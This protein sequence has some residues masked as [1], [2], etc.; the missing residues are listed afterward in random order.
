MRFE[1][2]NKALMTDAASLIAPMVPSPRQQSSA[3]SDQLSDADG[4]SAFSM[5]LHDNTNA[6][7]KARP[8]SGAPKH[9]SESKHAKPSGDSAKSKD[10][11]TASVDNSKPA[12]KDS[13]AKSHKSGKPDKKADAKA[14]NKDKSE[15]AAQQ[16]LVAASAT[17]A[18]PA[19]ATID[20]ATKKAADAAGVAEASDSA[21]AKGAPGAALPQADKNAKPGAQGN[22]LA[23]LAAVKP[24]VDGVPTTQ[25][26][27]KS[28][29]KDGGKESTAGNEA[30]AAL[31]V[32]TEGKTAD[33]KGATPK[34]AAASASQSALA[35]AKKDDAPKNGS[36]E[37]AA[38][39]NTNA[40]IGVSGTLAGAAQSKPAGQS[41][42]AGDGKTPPTP[43]AIVTTASSST[44]APVGDKLAA[45]PTDAASPKSD[46][47]AQQTLAATQDKPAPHQ[48]ANNIPP[49]QAHAADASAALKAAAQ[50]VQQNVPTQGAA[51]G[52]PQTQNSA[53]I[54]A[55]IIHAGDA[56]NQGAPTVQAQMDGPRL[57]LPMEQVAL[58]I[59]R[60]QSAGVD[61]FNIR[62]D[63]PDLGRIDVKIEV[64]SD[65]QAKAHLTADH[66]DTLNLLQ[67]D[68]SQLERALNNSGLKTSLNFS[69]R[70]DSGA[71]NRGSG[72]WNGNGPDPS[73]YWGG[74]EDDIPETITPVRA[75]IIDPTRIDILI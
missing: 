58:Q 36:Q 31:S 27:V 71:W 50:G 68:S 9:S 65:G 55:H 53:F 56:G 11:S 63:P 18:K 47:D 67:R 19:A 35:S 23:D 2:D 7:D 3:P 14:D 16:G 45:A 46:G 52:D 61:H 43:G 62:L 10:D 21:Q 69:L 33:A 59:R 51:Q 22:G 57:T 34:D 49:A 37:A 20:G 39:A 66:Q 38:G 64:S 4:D 44:K 26:S 60:H 25:Q 28:K 5:A 41:D 6:Q 17:P 30:S 12:D 42:K 1:R 70:Q 15:A 40:L 54:T 29:G 74:S 8:K 75:R 48:P 72:S 13:T 24:A 73:G 32:S